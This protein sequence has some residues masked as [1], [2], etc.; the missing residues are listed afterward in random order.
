MLSRVSSEES[1]ESHID[2]LPIRSPLGV[3][4]IV[5]RLVDDYQCEVFYFLIIYRHL[6]N[7]VDL[8][9][10]GTVFALRVTIK[11]EKIECEN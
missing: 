3:C 11:D 5:A 6:S 4:S 1:E 9:K 8:N 10:Q 2:L 7:V